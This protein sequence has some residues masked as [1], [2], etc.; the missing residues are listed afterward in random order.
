MSAIFPTSSRSNR[1]LRSFSR[2]LGTISRSANSRA[3]SRIR[4]C[5]SVSS[6]FTSP[7]IRKLRRD[8]LGQEAADSLGGGPGAVESDSIELG[9]ALNLAHARRE[10]DLRGREHVRELVVALLDRQKLEDPV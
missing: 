3:V 10:K 7:R 4:C 1:S 8:P 9:D 2:A 6:R 5:S